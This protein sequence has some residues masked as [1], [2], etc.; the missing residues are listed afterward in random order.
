MRFPREYSR[1]VTG[2]IRMGWENDLVALVATLL[3]E[4]KATTGISQH[5]G[6]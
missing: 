1:N 2:F 5:L 4:T 6:L 3:V